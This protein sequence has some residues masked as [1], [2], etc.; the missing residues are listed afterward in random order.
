[1]HVDRRRGP[2]LA[3]FTGKRLYNLVTRRV[4]KRTDGEGRRPKAGPW[5]EWDPPDGP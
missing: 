3:W 4:L 2:G 5:P 1:M